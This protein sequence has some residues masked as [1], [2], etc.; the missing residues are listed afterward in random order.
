[1]YFRLRIPQYVHPSSTLLLLT[2]ITKEGGN[3]SELTV[4]VTYSDPRIEPSVTLMIQ[5]NAILLYVLVC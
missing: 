3:G 2:A 5:Q 4:S 1:M